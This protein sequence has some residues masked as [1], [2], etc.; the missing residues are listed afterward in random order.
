MTGNKTK[1]SSWKNRSKKDRKE[2]EDQAGDKTLIVQ[3]PVS[4]SM[5]EMSVENG[6]IVN[7]RVFYASDYH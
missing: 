1:E 3:V 7:I 4:D 2:A 5:D 6:I